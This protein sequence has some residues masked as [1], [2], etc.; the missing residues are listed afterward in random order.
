MTPFKIFLTFLISFFI[1]FILSYRQ[2]VEKESQYQ[3]MNERLDKIEQQVQQLSETVS[4]LRK[5]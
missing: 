4:D 2:A 3:T 5:K 1:Y